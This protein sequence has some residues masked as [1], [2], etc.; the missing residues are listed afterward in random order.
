MKESTVTMLLAIGSRLKSAFSYLLRK[1]RFMSTVETEL[2]SIKT[3][4]KGT[5]KIL[6]AILRETRD[7]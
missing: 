5:N 7:E 6:V 1:E 3:Q 4:I 2:L